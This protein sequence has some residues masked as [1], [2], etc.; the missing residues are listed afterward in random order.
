MFENAIIM[1]ITDIKN[2]VR[3]FRTYVI[4]PRN[5]AKPKNLLF[6]DSRTTSVWGRI[7]IAERL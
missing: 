6:K 2:A 1:I 3:R 7:K 4:P 5:T